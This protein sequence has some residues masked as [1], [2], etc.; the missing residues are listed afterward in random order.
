M[1]NDALLKHLYDSLESCDESID[2]VASVIE[3]KGSTDGAFDA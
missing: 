3:S 2:V 1:M